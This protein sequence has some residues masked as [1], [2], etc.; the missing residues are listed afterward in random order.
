MNKNTLGLGSP[1]RSLQTPSVQPAGLYI[2]Q[3][4]VQPTKGDVSVAHNADCGG[5]TGFQLL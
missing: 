5:V 3:H 2:I 4:Q 1:A